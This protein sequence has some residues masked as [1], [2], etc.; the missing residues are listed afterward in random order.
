[1]IDTDLTCGDVASTPFRLRNDSTL[2]EALEEMIRRRIRR[3][4]V[5]DSNAFISDRTVIDYVFSPHGIQ[6]LREE[7]YSTKIQEIRA[8]D[9]T[10]VTGN[11]PLKEGARLLLRDKGKCLL[12]EEGLVTPWDCVV[13]PFQM[14][15]L[16]IQ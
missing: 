7:L 13:K 6:V 8:M 15:V 1:M 14:N 9:A 4:F 11:L 2:K 5:N 16:S 10:P 12:C 3:V